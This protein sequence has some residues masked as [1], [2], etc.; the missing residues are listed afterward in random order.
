[1]KLCRSARPSVHVWLWNRCEIELP[2]LIGVYSSDYYRSDGQ[3]ALST[4]NDRYTPT[5][6]QHALSTL[7]ARNLAAGIAHSLVQGM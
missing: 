5:I 6:V 4:I 1:M 3:L 7:S 2:I